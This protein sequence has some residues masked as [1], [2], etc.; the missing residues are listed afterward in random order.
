MTTTCAFKN[1]TDGQVTVQGQKSQ[2]I[3]TS[4]SATILLKGMLSS[5]SSDVDVNQLASN[6]KGNL[7]HDLLNSD[8]IPW[9]SDPSLYYVL[10]FQGILC[11]LASDTTEQV[12]EQLIRLTAQQAATMKSLE[13]QQHEM[14]KEK[15]R[16]KRKKH[17]A[18]G[19]LVKNFA[20]LSA[21]A[22]NP[23]ALAAQTIDAAV[24]AKKDHTSF[25]SEE[26]S[27]W[28]GTSKKIASNPDL[29]KTLEGLGIAATALMIIAGLLSGGVAMP[30]ALL[31]MM[32]VTQIPVDGKNGMQWLSQGVTEACLKDGMIKNKKHARLFGDC[33]ALAIGLTLA[34][35]TGAAAESMTGVGL[36]VAGSIL[37]SL[38][39][40]LTQDIFAMTSE[41]EKERDWILY[42][43]TATLL[44][45][46][47]TA[48]FAGGV[49]AASEVA[50]EGE[51]EASNCL[52]RT[53]QKLGTFLDKY[54]PQCLQNL[55]RNYIVEITVLTGLLQMTSAGLTVAKGAGDIL[56]ARIQEML[57]KLQATMGLLTNQ[58]DMTNQ[59]IQQVESFLDSALQ[60]YESS[61]SLGS[62]IVSGLTSFR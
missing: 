8:L 34:V 21:V 62:V 4:A 25:A 5:L 39:P 40:D 50:A 30:L 37:G 36:M 23:T 18:F 61:L 24:K 33:V 58:N 27:F 53:M 59:Q 60:G 6:F 14:K 20:K 51:A 12:N 19:S 28:G 55:C 45:L 11:T 47:I 43:L 38:T 32:L 7:I 2:Q 29:G 46:S 13:R 3:G 52:S 16:E 31:M 42:G 41:G 15:K 22:L 54:T 35:T 10:A 48:S 44:T 26:K 17:H 1:N 49:K 9:H 56:I 57:A